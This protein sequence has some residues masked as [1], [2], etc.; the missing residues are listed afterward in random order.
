MSG[1]IEAA[2]AAVTAGLAAGTLEGQEAKRAAHGSCPNCAA[3]TMGAYCHVCG[4]PAHVHRT[5]GHMV[6]EFLHGIVH[7]DTKAW[8]TLPYVVFRPGTLTRNYVHGKRARYISPL[9]L[10]LFMIFAM[11]F[12]FSLIEARGVG[13][14][15]GKTIAQA[16]IE[17]AAIKAQEVAARGALEAAQIRVDEADAMAAEARLA[18]DGAKLEAAQREV[19]AARI[20][21]A[22]AQKNLT[23]A[24]SQAAALD[25]DLAKSERDLAALTSSRDGLAKRIAAAEAAGEGGRAAGLRAGLARVQDAIEAQQSGEAALV[26]ESGLEINGDDISINFGQDQ[27]ARPYFIEEIKKAEAAGKIKVNTGNK[28]WDKKIHEKLANPELGLYKIQNT[29][30]KLSFMLVPISLPFLWLIFVW[31]RGVTLFDHTVFIL[32]SLSAASLMTIFLLALG[33]MPW[34]S[35]VLT[36]GLIF[37][38]A[39]LHMY[40]H[41][42]GAYALGW[43]GAGL[44]TVY[45][46]IASWFCLVIFTLAIIVLGLTG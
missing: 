21:F 10:F 36:A 39:P 29:A 24:Q 45:L 26:G 19:E 12:A 6:E 4:Q 38:G 41:L 25:E 40:F 30:Y 11:F 20:A 34:N 23:D 17:K 3:Q 35:E 2:G 44:R 37:I 33:A 46:L 43:L 9:A 14:P 1:E 31:K 13:L 28:N 22:Q 32:Y 27:D 16:R 18:S 7:F 42:K 8:R 5:L 15:V